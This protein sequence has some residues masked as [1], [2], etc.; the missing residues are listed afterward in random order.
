MNTKYTRFITFI[1][2]EDEGSIAAEETVEKALA[3][4]E[5]YFN[6]GGSDMHFEDIVGLYE[7]VGT[8]KINPFKLVKVEPKTKKAKKGK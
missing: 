7:L 5:K 2:P 6:D 1:D 3:E 4:T 8:Y